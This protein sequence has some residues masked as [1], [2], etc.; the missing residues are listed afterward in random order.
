MYNLTD[1]LL[2]DIGKCIIE[3]DMKGLEQ[4]LELVR[5]YDVKKKLSTSYIF[6]KSFFKACVNGNKTIILWLSNLFDQID[7]IEKMSI[8]QLFKYGK[9]L[10]RKHKSPGLDKWYYENVYLKHSARY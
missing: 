5:V 2:R 3:N 4:I 10:I 8:R 7:T 9:Y 1:I 6:Q